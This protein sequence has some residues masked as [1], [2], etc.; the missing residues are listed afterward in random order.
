MGHFSPVCVPEFTHISQRN[1]MDP[2]GMYGV[3]ESW[4]IKVDASNEHLMNC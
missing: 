1:F 3:S 4:T 2:H